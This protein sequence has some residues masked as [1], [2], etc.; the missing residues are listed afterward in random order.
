M[1]RGR[2]V[3]A[4]GL[5]QGALLEDRD[6]QPASASSAATGAPPAPVPIA[7]IGGTASPAIRSPIDGA[8]AHLG[9]AGDDRVGVVARG[10]RMTPASP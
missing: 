8:P 10:A 9:G 1:S 7:R 5:V 4:R 2:A 3:I 6:A